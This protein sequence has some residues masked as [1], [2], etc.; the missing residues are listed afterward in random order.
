MRPR[1]RASMAEGI[2]ILKG[3]AYVRGLAVLV[4]VSTVALTLGDYVFKSAVARAVPKEELGAFFGGLYAVLNLA[5]ARRAGRRRGLALPGGRASTA[6]C[7]CCPPSCSW[8]RRGSRSAAA[9]SPP[10]S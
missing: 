5:R 3:D 6:R 9:S 7:G 10:S 1:G 8:A 4:L 2:S